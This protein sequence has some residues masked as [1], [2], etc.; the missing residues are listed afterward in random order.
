MNAW[1]ER[2]KESARAFY[3]MLKQGNRGASV[4][5]YVVVNAGKRTHVA[6]PQ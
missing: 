4:R 2:S 6:R 3:V 1:P 5:K